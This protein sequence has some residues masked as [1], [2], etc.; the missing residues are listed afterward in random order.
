MRIA[1]SLLSVSLL[2]LVLSMLLPGRAGAATPIS[3]FIGANGTQLSLNGGAY[4][5]TGLNIYNA[6]T[7]NGANY[8]CYDQYGTG[9]LASLDQ[10]LANIDGSSRLGVGRC[11]PV[12][13]P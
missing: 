9:G 3:P 5:F 11:L 4:K 8:L 7:I 12:T 13:L 1:R 10:Q 2:F 6:A